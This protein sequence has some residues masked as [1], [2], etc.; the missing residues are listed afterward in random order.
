[1]P[2]PAIATFTLK[3]FQ[4][5]CNPQVIMF[6]KIASLDNWK[7]YTNNKGKVFIFKWKENQN[8]YIKE[9]PSHWGNKKLDA[10]ESTESCK[11]LTWILHSMRLYK[12]GHLQ[13]AY[14]NLVI[15]SMRTGFLLKLCFLTHPQEN[16]IQI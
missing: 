13:Q 8:K 3:R 1:M 9:G 6:R 12:H 15:A 4:F 7:F 16:A 14:N 10:I 5:F 11:L 2:V